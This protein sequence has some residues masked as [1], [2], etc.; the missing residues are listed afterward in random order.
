MH[1]LR[2][3]HGLVIEITFLPLGVPLGEAA[4]LNQ[5]YWH[6]R[7]DVGGY[8]LAFVN[9]YLLNERRVLQHIRRDVLCVG[10]ET[11]SDFFRR[12]LARRFFVVERVVRI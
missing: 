7:D 12:G 6:L 8:S 3:R 1:L 10:K 9:R 4:I 11:G 5:N 2:W